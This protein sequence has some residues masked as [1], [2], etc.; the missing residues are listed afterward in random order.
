MKV[1]QN[2]HC[3]ITQLGKFCCLSLSP[4][5]EYVQ[6]CILC[7]H[8]IEVAFTFDSI[9]EWKVW[10]NEQL[11]LSFAHHRNRERTELENG[12]SWI[13]VPS[14]MD[15]GPKV[16]FVLYCVNCGF[17]NSLPLDY[18]VIIPSFP[19]DPA[20]VL[21][22]ESVPAGTVSTIYTRIQLRKYW[23]LKLWKVHFSMSR[24]SLGSLGSSTDE[25]RSFS[26][27]SSMAF[28]LPEL[29]DFLT[30]KDLSQ[31]VDRAKND[32]LKNKQKV[33]VL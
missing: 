13:M 21:R 15:S 26:R 27:R 6:I 23:D 33:L 12:P 11:T 2:A 24:Q 17:I 18:R 3:L 29:A 4:I 25:L 8:T 14:N 20:T 31:I 10:I 22:R 28:H 30:E 7:W 5:I 9:F 32:A 16:N 1:F 19:R